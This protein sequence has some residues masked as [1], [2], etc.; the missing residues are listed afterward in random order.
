M[1][2]TTQLID[3]NYT[4]GSNTVFSYQIIQIIPDDLP[5]DIKVVV[6][7][8][9]ENDNSPRFTAGPGIF[10]HATSKVSRFSAGPVLTLGVSDTTSV[11]DLVATLKAED[12]DIDDII[13]YQITGGQ[14]KDSFSIEKY[15]GKIY[16]RI[17]VDTG[18]T[19]TVIVTAG[20]GKFS[21]DITV[22]F[23]VISSSDKVVLTIPITLPEFESK[24]TTILSNISHIVGFKV[25]LEKSGVHVD[26]KTHLDW[27]KTDIYFHGIN[28]T[29]GFILPQH[30]SFR[31]IHEK[32]KEIASLFSPPEIKVITYHTP[33]VPHKMSEA[34]IALL[35]IGVVILVSSLL[36]LI[37]ANYTWKQF[38]RSH[39][40]A[41]DKHWELNSINSSHANGSVV[42]RQNDDGYINPAFTETRFT[43]RE[44]QLPATN[45]IESE[46]IRRKREYES[47]EV[48]LDLPLEP[49]DAG[50]Q[51][52]AVD[53]A[54]EMSLN[55]YDSGL[56]N[57]IDST[58]SAS[59]NAEDA[60]Q[61]KEIR[62]ET[63]V[64]G[65]DKG[66]IELSEEAGPSQGQNVFT[67]DMET[68]DTD[69][70]ID[71]D[72]VEDSGV[73]RRKSSKK[74]FSRDLKVFPS[75]IETSDTDTDDN[76]DQSSSQKHLSRKT[77]SEPVGNQDQE[78]GEIILTK[79]DSN[80]DQ[81]HN[82]KP[83]TLLDQTEQI[84]RK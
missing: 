74:K 78:S 54:R 10:D 25:E 51:P 27:S 41:K 77:D 82:V 47:Q 11:G 21:T 80:S 23:L 26:S 37:A 53:G 4:D 3:L 55:G 24:S 29:G 61:D 66:D 19:Y 68:G 18:K 16:S 1:N 75:K 39:K 13:Q 56:E 6:Y 38:K 60:Q 69:D 71:D 79:E 63:V 34:E 73:K 31:I 35:T 72:E 46:T 57:E 7:V 9:D 76:P 67:F 81:I 14:D 40:T 84:N 70:D 49:I 5:G 43:E 83:E 58:S 45:V 36:S 12:V 62:I 8:Q 33:L 30:T 64:E 28:E 65:Q 52:P 50:L 2:T 59:G 22:K 48:V 44:E 42:M 20:D 15:K 32:S 17:N